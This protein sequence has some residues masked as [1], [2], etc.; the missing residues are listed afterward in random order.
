MLCDFR[1]ECWGPSKHSPGKTPVSNSPTATQPFV[2]K[3][4]HHH[5]T[6]LHMDTYCVLPCVCRVVTW[7]YS[8]LKMQGWVEC[9]RSLTGN[10]SLT[11]F[12][13]LS[14]ARRALSIFKDVPLT[15]R[16][17]LSLYK[18]YGDSSLLVLNGTS[19][20]WIVIAPFWLSTD[21]FPYIQYPQ[22]HH[23][24]WCPCSFIVHVPESRPMQWC[25]AVSVGLSCIWNWENFKG[26]HV[27]L[28][29]MTATH[30]SKSSAPN[31]TPHP[32]GEFFF[33]KQAIQN[34]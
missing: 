3:V 11:R 14:R 8:T 23:I 34:S 10:Q 9:G 26:L 20:K 21:I 31:P 16:R 2:F 27:G 12:V 29:I 18:V 7:W 32:G 6:I 33:P 17:V 15:T 1:T 28:P 25:C 5:N 22:D 30:Q 19:L 24:L 4:M 13:C